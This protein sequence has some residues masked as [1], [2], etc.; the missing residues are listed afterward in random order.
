MSQV[1]SAVCNRHDRG[2]ERRVL[3]L[4]VVTAS[5]LRGRK[6]RTKFYRVI[7]IDSSENHRVLLSYFYTSNVLATLFRATFLSFATFANFEIFQPEF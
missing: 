6:C 1:T 5:P 4:V 7:E 2:L 3:V